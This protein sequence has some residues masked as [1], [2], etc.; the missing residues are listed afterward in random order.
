MAIKR[1]PH[2]PVAFDGFMEA[3]QKNLDRAE[4]DPAYLEEITS[5]QIGNPMTLGPRVATPDEWAND[6]V[7]A[8]SNKAA[9]W[10]ANSLKPRKD[11][12][13]RALR[14]TEKHRANTQAALDEGRWAK[15]INAY[16]ENVRAAVIEAVGEE[17]FRGGINKK[18]VKIKAAIDKLQPMVAALT[19][20]LDAMP[21]D[22]ADQRAQK[23]IAARDG[24]IAIK[25]RLRG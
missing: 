20:T 23:M 1:K 25:Q 4:N 6:M 21:I 22:T 16:D 7:Q 10:K 18:K 2:P 14:A 5:D 3:L 24:M 15:G 13:Q 17:G 8:A 12:K 19:D 9:K 11:P